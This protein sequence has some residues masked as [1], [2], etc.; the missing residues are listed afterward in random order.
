MVIRAYPLNVTCNTSG[1]QDGGSPQA[2]RMA[3]LAARCGGPMVF[4]YNS[5]FE[6]PI[7]IDNAPIFLP[8]TDR[9]SPAGFRPS[10]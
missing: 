8:L 3:D 4:S 9:F 7:P 2:L 10:G 1:W 5:D 6:E